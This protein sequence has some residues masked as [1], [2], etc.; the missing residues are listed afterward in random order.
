MLFDDAATVQ[1]YVMSLG[2]ALHR[3]IGIAI[4]KCFAAVVKFLGAVAEH[5]PVLGQHHKVGPILSCFSHE[6][7]C[8]GDVFRFVGLRI[9]LD[10]GDFHGVPR[11]DT[12]IDL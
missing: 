12:D 5:C 7:L 9:H 10:K 3:A 1:R 11:A 2:H 6:S 8:C 4:G